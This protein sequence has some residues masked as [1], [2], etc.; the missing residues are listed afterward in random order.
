MFPLR[1]D[2]LFISSGGGFYWPLVF[3]ALSAEMFDTKKSVLC[4]EEISI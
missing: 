4:V 1:N 3:W 2:L